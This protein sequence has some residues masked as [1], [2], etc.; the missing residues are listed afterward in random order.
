MST[1]TRKEVETAEAELRKSA[2]RLRK[3][4]KTKQIRIEVRVHHGLVLTARETRTTI[5]K[6]ASK[7][8]W[9]HVRRNVIKEARERP[10]NNL[11]NL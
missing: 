2:K 7:I 8:C 9:P 10:N 6:L 3:K 1:I 11:S 5:S 4:R